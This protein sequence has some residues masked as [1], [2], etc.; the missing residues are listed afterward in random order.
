MAAVLGD[1]DL[2]R[3]YSLLAYKL[4]TNWTPPFACTDRLLLLLLTRT[5]GCVLERLSNV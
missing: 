3:Y 5:G 4:N 1:I 2:P